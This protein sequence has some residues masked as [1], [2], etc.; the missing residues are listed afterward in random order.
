MEED[1]SV[2][3][4]VEQL[5][6]GP[7]P[8]VPDGP[9]PPNRAGI[10]IGLALL[11]IVAIVFLRPSDGFT[12]AG[13]QRSA[14]T[15]TTTPVVETDDEIEDGEEVDADSEEIESIVQVIDELAGV[16][17]VIQTPTGYFALIASPTDTAGAVPL[18]HSSNGESWIAVETSIANDA[19]PSQFAVSFDGL[20]FDG[21]QYSVVRTDSGEFWGRLVEVLVSNDGAWWEVAERVRID[22]TD[23]VQMI[24]GPAVGILSEIETES[25]L[26][27]GLLQDSLDAA[28]GGFPCDV[29]VRDNQLQLGSCS[30]DHQVL[31]DPEG[32][33]AVSTVDGDTATG[34]EVLACVED[35]SAVDNF[36]PQSLRIVGV[37]AAG[38]TRIVRDRPLSGPSLL[39]DGTVITIAAAQPRIEVPACDRFG[40]ETINATPRFVQ[41]WVGLGEADIGAV[42][43]QVG[44][45]G[46]PV[47]EIEAAHVQSDGLLVLAT[48]ALWSLYGDGTWRWVVQT[49][50]ELG[51]LSP[52]ARILGDL[53][54]DELHLWDLDGRVATNERT[55]SLAGAELDE[56]L[57]LDDRIAVVR[58][59]GEVGVIDLAVDSGDE[60]GSLRP[61]PRFQPQ[62]GGI[63]RTE[64][65]FLGLA[66]VSEAG[67]P[68]LFSST[69]GEQWSPVEVVLPDIESGDA[70]VGGVEY[71]N[72]IATDVGFALLRWEMIVEQAAPDPGNLR[73]IRLISTDGTTWE[74]DPNAVPYDGS[75][76]PLIVNEPDGFVVV[77]ADVTRRVAAF[78]S[79]PDGLLASISFDSPSA[80][81]ASI[82][83]TNDRTGELRQVPLPGEVHDSLITE[84]PRPLVRGMGSTLFTILDTAVWSLD[85]ETE[86]WSRLGDLPMSTRGYSEFSFAPDGR[87]I[88]AGPGGLV[89]VDYVLGDVSVQ[90]AS[91]WTNPRIVFVDNAAAVIALDDRPATINVSLG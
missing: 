16:S 90:S 48:D 44:E 42:P 61:V 23:D 55:Y 29:S 11:V 85:L 2:R 33:G 18:L 1:R 54:G 40:I 35:L 13:T 5:S 32:L 75:G 58:Q 84:W 74:L 31:L 39:D 63:V 83:I 14:P 10:A 59:S 91:L 38:D 81:S 53:Q 41:R 15:S 80:S 3:I 9:A 70:V 88:A 36:P 64:F 60:A 77:D 76:E 87:L 73:V 20:E 62:D 86:A 8:E 30:N 28:V 25:P 56:F 79:L 12:A 22:P 82:Q 49:P 50:G 17:E 67:R 51:Y 78:T 68:S 65:G 7:S 4:E 19:L 45:E 89:V 66:Q 57:Y 37:D 47:L 26:E 34:A 27:L 43:S 72:L 6:S 21:A 52:D 24:E 46:D 69:T 71:S